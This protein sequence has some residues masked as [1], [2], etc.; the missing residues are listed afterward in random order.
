[1]IPHL[2]PTPTVYLDIKRKHDYTS[3]DIKI[4]R[5]NPMSKPALRIQSPGAGEAPYLR[6]PEYIALRHYESLKERIAAG[7]AAFGRPLSTAEKALISHLRGWNGVPP[8]PGETY[9]EFQPDRVALQDALAQIVALQFITAGLDEVVVPTTVHCDHLITART[10]AVIDLRSAKDSNAEIY[11]FLRSVC[12]RYGMGFWEPG[13]GIIHQVVLENYA[14]PGGMMIGTDSHTPNA[15]GLAMLSVGVGGGDAIDVMTGLPFTLRWP[16][17]IGVHLTGALSGWTSPKDVILKVAELLSVSGGT[18]AI[19]EYFG[20]GA[21]TISATGKATICNMGAEIGATTSIFPYDENT[22]AYLRATFRGALADRCDEVSSDLR[23][24]PELEHDPSRFFDAVLEVDLSA[25][26]PLIN[27][28]DTPDLSHL[29]GQAGAWARAHNVPVEISAALVGSCTNSSYEDISRAASVARRAKEFGLSAKVPLFITPGSEQIRATVERDGY[30]DDLRAIGATVLAN[31][32][33]PCIGQWDRQLSDPTQ[34][35][36]IVSSFNRNFARRNDG[37]AATKS[38]LASPEI[39]VALSLAGSLDF[40]PVVDTIAAADGRLVHLELPAGTVLPFDGFVATTAPDVKYADPF[41]TISVDPSSTRL[42]LLTPF[43]AWDGRD[44]LNMPVL[45][46]ASGKCTTDQISAAGKWLAYRGHLEHISDNLFLGVVNAFSGAIGE[47]RDPI[48]DTV[49][50]FPESAKHLSEMD[51]TWCFIGD[52]NM[53]EGSSREL[54]AMEPRFRGGK[55]AIARSF[56]RIFETNLKKQGVLALTF[57]DPATYDL[58]RE[59]DRISVTGLTALEPGRDVNCSINHLD[60]SVTAFSCS[61]TCTPEQIEW[62]TTGSAL[63]VTRAL[64]D[65]SPA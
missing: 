57:C 44:Y 14:F 11:D 59:D 2:T 12:D 1:M 30:L 50:P 15:G 33:G 51:L 20:P 39:V 29:V 26:R 31:A 41:R 21:S 27:G 36:S 28:P 63:N 60:G 5:R 52:A 9:A 54:A 35:N 49:R 56:A 45:A 18:G 65:H 8:V 24:D 38:F 58:I 53:G 61:H 55:V 19:I 6:S 7:R 16:T 34:L 17:L 4:N 32:C 62:F 46:K 3:L 42:Q 40:D 23:A 64:H 47:G 37:N 22:A 48:D 43:G 13:A 10:N 25:L